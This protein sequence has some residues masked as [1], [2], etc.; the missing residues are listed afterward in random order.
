[1]NLNYYLAP[2]FRLREFLIGS[3]SASLNK[4]NVDYFLNHASLFVL[5]HLFGLARILETIRALYGQPITITSGYRCPNV[6]SEVGGVKNSYHTLALAVDLRITPG[7]FEAVKQAIDLAMIP[8]PR[9]FI[10]KKNLLY[11]HLAFDSA[12]LNDPIL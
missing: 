11:I 7:L 2:H 4:E 1:M 9:E 6:N 8:N 3:R 12:Q 5:Y 10:V